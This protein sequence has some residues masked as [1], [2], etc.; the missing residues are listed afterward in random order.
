MNAEPIQSVAADSTESGIS[1]GGAWSHRDR[2]AQP[3]R[4]LGPKASL[5]QSRR[6]Q[7]DAA[8]AGAHAAAR[9]AVQLTTADAAVTF[10]LKASGSA[11][12][13]ER[14]Q[15]RPLGAHVVQCMVFAS[16]DDFARWCDAD[17][18][19]FDDPGLHQRL[20]RRGR[21]FFGGGH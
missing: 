14:I 9:E 6:Q 10:V 20:C 11:L 1:A 19:R 13:V 16:A 5:L 18:L 17:P 3:A 4:A 21:E 12:Y 15:R 7:R 8:R 2:A